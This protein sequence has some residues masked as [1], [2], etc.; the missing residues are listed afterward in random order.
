MIKHIILDV[1]GT[2]TD[3][4]RL[5]STEAIE[6]IRLG[7]GNGIKVSLISGNVIPVMFG[8]KTFIGINGTVFGEN[9]G[10]MLENDHIVSF[11]DKTKAA[12][13]LEKMV[14]DVNVKPMFTNMWRESSVA[15]LLNGADPEYISKKA[16]K[17]GLYIVNSRFTWHVM[18]S[19]QDKA[20]AVNY[21]INHYNLN[22]NEI[23][24]VGDSDN[25]NSMFDLDVL[26]A[27]P[28]NATDYIKLKS[29]FVSEKSYGNEIMDILKHYSIL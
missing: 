4:K 20:Y 26:R 11:F 7:I 13:F 10:V 18:N 5:I 23:L 22:N 21:L 24:V 9:G 2:I 16:Y 8:L 27:C 3:Q 19:G 17:E 29:D 6:A 28:A 15:F 12:K 14:N 1:D 25:D